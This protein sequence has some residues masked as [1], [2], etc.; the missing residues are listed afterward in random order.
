MWSFSSD[1]TYQQGFMTADPLHIEYFFV[2]PT[3]LSTL[4]TVCENSRRSSD[5]DIDVTVKAQRSQHSD[6]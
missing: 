1:L 6:V 5:A 4:E 3:I 2:F